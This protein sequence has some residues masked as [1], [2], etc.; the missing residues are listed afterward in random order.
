MKLNREAI[1][2]AAKQEHMTIFGIF[3]LCDMAMLLAILAAWW[4][5]PSIVT[6]FGISLEFGYQVFKLICASIEGLIIGILWL[7]VTWA[8]LIVVDCLN[9]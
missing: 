4:F 8:G 9:E 2:N 5:W 3:I 1:K 7:V 6:R